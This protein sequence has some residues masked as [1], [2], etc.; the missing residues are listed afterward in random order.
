M[1]NLI[2]CCLKCYE[3]LNDVFCYKNKLLNIENMIKFK[4]LSYTGTV[5]GSPGTVMGVLGCPMVSCGNQIH[6]KSTIYRKAL[7][8]T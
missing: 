2:L 6:L 4:R 7:I 5:M 3:G 1:Q 8:N